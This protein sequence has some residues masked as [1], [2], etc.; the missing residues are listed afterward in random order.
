MD[1]VD[2]KIIGLLIQDPQMPFSGM[3]KALDVG[4][5]TVIRRYNKLKSEGV[6][7]NTTVTVD[8]KKCG[9]VG[10]ALFLVNTLAGAEPEKMYSELVKKRNV[11]TVIHAIGDYDLLIH[12]IYS[13][14]D[15][16][17]RLQKEISTVLGIKYMSVVVVSAKE[18]N[19]SF[20]SP[21]YYSNI[22]A[23]MAGAYAQIKT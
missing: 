11:L 17:Y 14:L 4:I 15:D 1:I 6:I 5:E 13:D 21:E 10:H 9:Y 19:T 16:L 3:A 23:K 7:Y 2:L 18:F 8:M 20:P 22:I 12:C